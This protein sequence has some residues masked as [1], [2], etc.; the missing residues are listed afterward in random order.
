MSDKNT[1][2]PLLK[3]VPYVLALG[4]GVIAFLIYHRD[5]RKAIEKA[6]VDFPL[7]TFDE[8]V[9]DKVLEIYCPP[10]VRCATPPFWIVLEGNRKISIKTYDDSES[11]ATFA[12]IISIGDSLVKRKGSDTLFVFEDEKVSKFPLKFILE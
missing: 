12:S 9:S 2:H 4:I 6:N 11:K 7:L 1:I 8:A 3:V 5:A 10:E